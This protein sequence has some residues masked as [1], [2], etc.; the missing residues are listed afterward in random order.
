MSTDPNPQRKRR[1]LNKQKVDRY[2]KYSGMAFQ[3]LAMLLLAAF[4]GNYLDEKFSFEQPYMT[5]LFILV[6]FSAYIIRLY[7]DL[8]K[9]DQ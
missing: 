3:L 6:F 1:R 8:N 9:K 5:I 7:I 2:L 4:I